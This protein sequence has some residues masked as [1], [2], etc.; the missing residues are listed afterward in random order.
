M[1]VTAE[2]AGMSEIVAEHVEAV[3]R[4]EK[5]ARPDARTEFP[6]VRRQPSGTYGAQIWDPSLRA[7]VWLGSFG[8][9]EEAAGAYAAKL[10]RVRMMAK[11]KKAARRPDVRTEFRGVHR[12]LSGK[13]GA[14]IWDPK[15]KAR[16]WLGTFATAEE[17]ARAYDDAAVKLRGA[18]AITNFKQPTAA[19]ANG[20]VSCD[21]CEEKDAAAK[22]SRPSQAAGSPTTMVKKAG[23]RG[24]GC[25]WEERTPPS[26]HDTAAVNLRGVAAKANSKNP[27]APAF[28]VKT[29]KSISRSGFRGVVRSGSKY[30][31]QIVDPVPRA[32]LWLG[33]FDTAEEA[34]RAYDAAAV[35]L[36]S[37]K[38]ITNFEQQ[39]MAATAASDGEESSVDLLND[40]PEVPALD[41]LS[42]NIIPPVLQPD[43]LWTDLPTSKEEQMMVDEFLNDMDF[44]DVVA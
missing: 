14:Q 3:E 15:R 40:F 26:A 34:A 8:T 16:T 29:C 41:F 23:A 42:Y 4:R 36:Y 2:S 10:Y 19:T 21:W 38:A 44:P 22:S 1:V 33:T 5:K 39:P 7:L 11:K 28:G 37:A 30:G 9:A 20:S 35:R 25:R 6:G 43:D 24:L 27:A 17:A 18:R 32:S 13:Y 31:A 12:T